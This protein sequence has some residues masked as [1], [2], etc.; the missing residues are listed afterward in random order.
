[1]KYLATF[2]L[3]A[4]ATQHVSAEVPNF[5]LIYADESATDE[6]YGYWKYRTDYNN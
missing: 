3:L 5:I 4:L 6:V 1:M 2:L